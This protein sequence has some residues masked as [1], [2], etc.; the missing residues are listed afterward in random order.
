M[1]DGGGHR[2]VVTTVDAGQ[3]M[4]VPG[5]VKEDRTGVIGYR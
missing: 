4:M 1:N 2:P 5:L 3:P